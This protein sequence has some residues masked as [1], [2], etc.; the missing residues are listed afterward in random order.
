GGRLGRPDCARLSSA[1]GRGARDD[2]AVVVSVAVVALVDIGVDPGSADPDLRGPARLDVAGIEALAV[3]RPKSV[4]LI[5]AVDEP[6][7][8]AR[9]DV[10]LAVAQPARDGDGHVRRAGHGVVSTDRADGEGQRLDRDGEEG[11][12]ERGRSMWH[13]S[14]RRGGPR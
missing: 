5:V 2:P 4:A 1:A 7:D 9:L 8:R 13:T 6:D 11:K 10:D 14:S 3:A 12:D